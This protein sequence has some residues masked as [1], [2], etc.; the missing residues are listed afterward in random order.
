MAR[1][2]QRNAANKPSVDCLVQ[3]VPL[4]IIEPFRIR[5]KVIALRGAFVSSWINSSDYVKDE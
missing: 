3:S 2:S 5:R 1:S 4:G